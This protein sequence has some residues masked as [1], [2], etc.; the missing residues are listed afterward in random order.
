MRT[1]EAPARNRLAAGSGPEGAVIEAVSSRVRPILMTMTTT[2]FGMSPLVLSSGSGAE[3]YRGLGSILIGGLI[4]STLFTLILVPTVLSLVLR[5][6]R[7]P[8][9]ILES[10]TPG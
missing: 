9:A 6:A 1:E 7:E 10:R 8:R 4:V 5:E 3:L 2:V